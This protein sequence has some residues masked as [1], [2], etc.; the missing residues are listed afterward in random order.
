[1]Y[2]VQANLFFCE[3][4]RKAFFAEEKAIG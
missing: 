2:F 1:V 4:C 3:N